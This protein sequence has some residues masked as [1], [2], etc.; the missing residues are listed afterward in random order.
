MDAV[1]L[2]LLSKRRRSSREEE[3]RCGEVQRGF[4]CWPLSIAG[5]P[6][7]VETFEFAS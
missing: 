1:V 3:T 4:Y 2:G 7:R 6:S 5:G